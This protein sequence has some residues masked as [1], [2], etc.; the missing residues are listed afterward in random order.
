MSADPGFPAQKAFT[1][2]LCLERALAAIANRASE[3]H[4]Q[5]GERSMARA[6]NAFDVEPMRKSVFPVAGMLLATSARPSPPA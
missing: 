6:V 5:D 3:R 2:P 1:A 4:Q